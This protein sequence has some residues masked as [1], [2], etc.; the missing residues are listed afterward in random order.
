[1]HVDDETRLR[2]ML[3][4]AREATDMAA[5]QQRVDLDT[6][7]K[8]C[9]SLVH[10]LEIVGEAA[11]GVSQEARRRHVELPWKRMRGM[12]NRL[13]HAYFDVNLDVVWQTIQED[14]PGLVAQLEGILGD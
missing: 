5:G 9:L 1:M 8:L 10:L 7:R 6:D 4:A 3:D 13:I 2:H 12:R 11:A 14:L